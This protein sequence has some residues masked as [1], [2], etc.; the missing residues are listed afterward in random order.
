[1]G[2]SWG[3]ASLR[4]E[5]ARPRA[6]S[7]PDHVCARS[8]FVPCPAECLQVATLHAFLLSQ[9]DLLSSFCVDDVYL[10]LC[11]ESA[12]ARIH[13]CTMRAWTRTIWRACAFVRACWI[14]RQLSITTGCIFLSSPSHLLV[15]Q[16]LAHKGLAHFQRIFST[17][18]TH[19]QH[20]FSP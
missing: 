17:F 12:H 19:V 11:M 8:T 13:A 18:S 15:R 4:G 9:V 20:I 10:C 3:T 14:N 1:M 2:M 6:C 16:L 5:Y 7:T